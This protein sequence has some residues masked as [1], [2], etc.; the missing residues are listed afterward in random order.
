MKFP[1]AMRAK[2]YSDAKAAD[3]ILIQQVRCKA[4][5]IKGGDVPHPESAALATVAMTARPVLRMISTK[6]TVD[7][8][9]AVGGIG[10]SILP[11]PER[12]VRKLSHQV[13]IRKQNKRKRKAIHA[14]SHAQVTTLVAEERAKP[15]EDR[16]TT[17]QV[18]A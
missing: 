17:A 8:V 6:Q 16:R 7:P 13:Q 10:A 9:S 1:D 11:S 4:R 5:K 18:I 3:R 14:Q 15:R 2:G 12:K